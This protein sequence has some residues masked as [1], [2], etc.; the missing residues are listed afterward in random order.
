MEGK[1]GRR[2]QRTRRSWR[3]DRREQDRAKNEERKEM[4]TK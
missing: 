2:H 1:R 3:T 4:V